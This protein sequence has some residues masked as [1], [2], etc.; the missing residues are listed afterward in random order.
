MPSKTN[1]AALETLIY[2]Y[3]VDRNHYQSGNLSD[4]DPNLAIDTAKL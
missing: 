2:N 3:L 1:E 4:Y